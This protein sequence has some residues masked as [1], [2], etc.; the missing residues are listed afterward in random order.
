MGMM[1]M[2]NTKLSK[3]IK[4]GRT[5]FQK[6]KIKISPNNRHPLRFKLQRKYNNKL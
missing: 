3:K 6:Q 4:K 1:G 2:V 5:W